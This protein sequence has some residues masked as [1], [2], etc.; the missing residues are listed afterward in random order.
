MKK[1]KKMKRSTVVTLSVILVFAL[2]IGAVA[3]VYLLQQ[4]KVGVF[5]GRI[6]L[7]RQTQDNESELVVKVDGVEVGHDYAL[8]GYGEN[9][10]PVLTGVNAVENHSGDV[11]WEGNE[12][13]PIASPTFAITAKN[14]SVSNLTYNIA[15]TGNPSVVSAMRFGVVT[16]YYDDDLQTKVCRTEFAE[17]NED[18]TV[19]DGNLAEDE[20]ISVSVVAWADA[21]AL[22]NLKNFDD[23][24]FNVDIIFSGGEAA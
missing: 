5:S 1:L 2:A 21:Y 4:A 19:G 16:K 9:L 18:L 8:S 12:G 20:E 22:A 23:I 17:A 24:S 10:F 7:S 15:I 6:D 14:G 13:A 3:A 11:V